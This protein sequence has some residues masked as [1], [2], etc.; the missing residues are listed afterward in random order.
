MEVKPQKSISR[1]TAKPFGLVFGFLV[2]CH[3]SQ[4]DLASAEVDQVPLAFIVALFRH[5][6]HDELSFLQRILLILLV[7]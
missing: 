4:L 5:N 7:L 2:R 3:L 1:F 6:L